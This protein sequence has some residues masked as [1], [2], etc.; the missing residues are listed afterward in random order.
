MHICAKCK[1]D[2]EDSFEL[3]SGCYSCKSKAFVTK[4][5]EEK[6]VKNGDIEGVKVHEK[7]VYTIDIEK[8]VNNPL[9]INDEKGIY[10]IRIPN[11]NGMKKEN[12]FLKFGNGKG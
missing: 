5:D 10:H 3:V 8:A 7:G 2:I 9:V 12:G 6:P 1:K 11:Q 4:K